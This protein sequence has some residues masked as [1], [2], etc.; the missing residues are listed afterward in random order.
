M[1]D[2]T[3]FTTFRGRLEDLAVLARYFLAKGYTP[4]SRSELLDFA[5]KTVVENLTT[6][7]PEL[8]VSSIEEALELLQSLGLAKLGTR[9]VPT[10][11]LAR[12]MS[13]TEYAELGGGAMN[14]AITQKTTQQVRQGQAAQVAELLELARQ[15]QLQEQDKKGMYVQTDHLPIVQ[16]DE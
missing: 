2:A 1:S 11:P 6:Q 10:R 8:N 13:L 3:Y 16:E 9:N 12:Q 14:E 4:R 7:Q 5:V 15:R